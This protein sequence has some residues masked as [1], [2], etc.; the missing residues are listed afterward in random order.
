MPIPQNTVANNKTKVESGNL[1]LPDA[2][3]GDFKTKEAKKERQAA[4]DAKLNEIMIV[5][6]I[7]EM[8]NLEN[9][10]ILIQ[11]LNIFLVVLIEKYHYQ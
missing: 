4:E 3:T 10:I 11:I 7:F 1:G 9:C 2:G 5:L 8:E 6:F